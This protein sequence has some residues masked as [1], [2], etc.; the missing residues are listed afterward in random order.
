VQGIRRQV[1][2]LDALSSG[3][4]SGVSMIEVCAA[5]GL[6]KG[7]VHRILDALR[8]HGLVVREDTKR[9]RL[10]P[11]A[12]FWAGRY[13]EGPTSLAPLRGYVRRLSR[14][15]QFFAY[16]SVL[17]EG[18]LVC[19]AVERPG[20]K[21]HFF[22]QLGSRVP[23]LSTAAAKA[24]LAHQPEEVTSPL[25]ERAV[26]DEQETR[27]GKVT[28]SSYTQELAEARREGYAR[29]MEE[30]EIGVSAIGAPVLDV[31][32]R[33]VASLSVVAPTAALVR[34]WEPTVEKLRLVA[35]EASTMLGWGTQ[36]KVV[37]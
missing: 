28:V 24:I 8:E 5:T 20:T 11:R 1:A 15:T 13:L 14:E 17:D 22:V 19:V 4:D 9:W 36:E 2:I 32:S 3:L 12:A 30:L 26:A 23:V 7:T 18:Y 21:A 10:G 25:V 27:I 33:S 6:P 37:R 35:R 29:C 34:D 16:L 31:R